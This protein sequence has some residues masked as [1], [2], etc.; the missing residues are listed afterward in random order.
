MKNSIGIYGLGVMGASIA[1]NLAN[2]KFRVAV[3]NYTPDLTE[4]F[5]NEYSSDYVD[6]YFQL[7]NFVHSLERP[8]KILIMVTAGPVVDSVIRSLVPLLDKG[9]I[10]MDGGN[11]DFHDSNRRYHKLRELGFHF[12]SIGVS[13]GEKGAL[14]GPSLMPSG[15]MAVYQQVDPILKTISAKVNGTPCCTYIGPE[16]AGHYVKMIHNGI[17]YAEMQLIAEAYHF[18]RQKL[19]LNLE[20]IARLFKDWNEG[21]LH[22]YLIKITSEILARTDDE[23]G[24]PLIDMILDQAGQKGTG[25]WAVRNALELGVPLS[26]IAESVF[27]RFLSSMKQE[28]VKASKVLCGI[29]SGSDEGNKEEIIE[30]VRRALYMSKICVYSQGFSQL[31]RASEEYR[32]G[33]KCGDIAMIWRG[34]CILQSSFLQKI[35][36]AYDCNP[37][38][39]NLLLD[40][41]FKEIAEAYQTSLRKVVSMAVLGGIPVPAF[42]SAI[43]YYDSYRSDHLPANL[44]QAQRDYFGAHGYERI[45]KEGT[46]HTDWQ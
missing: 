16:G 23:T 34:G 33:L 41:S 37:N 11:S 17:E 26:T 27:A 13:G 2:H 14:T 15:S 30:D 5:L 44:I 28:R 42:A 39:E 18:L 31:S 32:W 20:E 4:K 35:K 36:D 12:L 43:N 21:E 45:D 19:G 3:Y 8:R 40:D 6:P 10:I 46:F 29:E 38:L 1:K 22:G 7:E 9:D 24:K 25:K